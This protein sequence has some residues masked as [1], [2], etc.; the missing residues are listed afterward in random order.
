MFCIGAAPCYLLVVL[1]RAMLM[2]SLFREGLDSEHAILQASSGW[3]ATRDGGKTWSSI[4]S[5]SNRSSPT[6]PAS[7]TPVP[8]SD[9]AGLVGAHTLLH[10][11][12][13]PAGF[14]GRH[15]GNE[16]RCTFGNTLHNGYKYVYNTQRGTPSAACGQDAGCWCCRCNCNATNPSQCVPPPPAPRSPPQSAAASVLLPNGVLRGVSVHAPDKNATYTSLS[17]TMSTTFFW[18]ASSSTW[19]FNTSTHLPTTF[20]GIPSPGVGCGNAKHAFGCPFRLSG[21]GYVRLPGG[22]LVMSAIV[23][24]QQWANPDPTLAA[25]STSIVAFRSTN[26]GLDWTYA[27]LIAAARDVPTSE[28]GPNENDLVLAG[29]GKTILCVF[30]TDAGD[31]PTTHRYAPYA[32]AASSD[33]G[34]TWTKGVSLGKGVG[35]ARPRLLR[36]AT[37]GD[38]ILAGGRPTPTSSDILLWIHPSSTNASAYAAGWVAHSI[39]YWHNVLEP[40]P[41]LHFTQEVN[42]TG[43]GKLFRQ[44]SSYTSLVKTGADGQSG[45]VTYARHLPPHPDLAFSMSFVVEEVGDEVE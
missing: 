12:P 19:A 44:S 31:G 15:G 8:N 38:V 33:G 7:P 1:T 16:Q 41:S 25:E 27:G 24:A 17:S 32:L 22:T 20:R 18:D 3:T 10:C 40:D 34:T 26:E 11:T 6:S 35:C 5:W 21:R 36:A 2:P 37:S 42:G 14:P 28:E 43:G 45:F 30:R 23:W 9:G 13:F 4:T 39:S 29:D